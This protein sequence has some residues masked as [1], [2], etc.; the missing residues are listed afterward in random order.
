VEADPSHLEQV[1]LNLVVNARDA[2]PEGGTLRLE[3]STV[4]LD[5]AYERQHPG[6]KSGRHVLLAVSDTGTGMSRDVQAKA[7][8]P[9][10]TTKSKGMGTGLGL[11]TTFGIVKQ[12]GG[13]ITLYSEEGTGTVVRVFLPVAADQSAT[14]TEAERSS[15]RVA[16]GERILVVEDEEGVRRVAARILTG[17]GY[18]AVCACGPDEA[19]ELCERMAVDLV[20]TDVVMPQMS[21]AMLVARMREDVPGLPAIFMSGYTDRPGALPPDAE[22]LGKPFSRHDLLALVART[23]G[24]NREPT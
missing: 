22:F 13:H 7:F 23:L 8:E 4:E 14:P 10:F 18:E 19:L 1:V 21:G 12:N 9:F 17:H 24:K 5:D 6:M 16:A 20:L 2:M 3:T 15:P 11:A